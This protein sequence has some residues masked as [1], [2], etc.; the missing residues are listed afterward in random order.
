MV[1]D[2]PLVHFHLLLL[3]GMIGQDR[4]EFISVQTVAALKNSVYDHQ[5]IEF[6]AQA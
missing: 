6:R 1:Y 2:Y 5:E 3:V 4:S